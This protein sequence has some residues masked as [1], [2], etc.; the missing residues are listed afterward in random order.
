[1]FVEFF[2]IW[3]VTLISISTTSFLAVSFVLVVTGTIEELDSNEKGELQG[4]AT[5]VLGCWSVGLS[6]ILSQIVFIVR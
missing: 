3:I 5:I 6:L 2:I 1:M 4:F